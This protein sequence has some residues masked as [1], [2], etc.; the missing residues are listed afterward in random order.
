MLNFSI[1]KKKLVFKKEVSNS[2]YSFKKN[3][4]FFII[5]FTNNNIGIGECNPLLEEKCPNFLYRFKNELKNVIS[6]ISYIKKYDIYHYRKYISYSSLFFGL[7]QV[8]LSLKEKYPILYHSDFTKGTKSM[9]I[10]DVIWINT[11]KKQKIIQKIEDKIDK[12]FL[13]LK[14]KMS[15]ELF[16]EQYFILKKLQDR[17]PL[18]RIHID[19]NGCFRNRKEAI[20]FIEKL[21]DINIV[22]LLEQPIPPSYWNDMHHICKKSK[23]SIALDEE[24]IKIKNIE[25]KRRLLDYI[26]PD[27]IILKPSMNNGF[28]GSEEWIKE[29]CERNIKWYIS[30][31][32]ES[33]IGMNA[34]AQ[35]TFIMEKKYNKGKQ[36]YHGLNTHCVYTNNFRSFLRIKKGLVRYHSSFQCKIEDLYKKMEQCG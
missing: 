17:Y 19:A 1:R 28:F 14:I 20:L 3:I 29:A 9:F 5:L 15:K 32:L 16:N 34:I 11:W 33:N 21:Y 26:N 22:V 27:Y 6:K 35:W 7:E 8:F 25:N 18:L 13:Y 36:M 23:I 24:L 4:I 10:N 2:N 31:S 12:G 30:S